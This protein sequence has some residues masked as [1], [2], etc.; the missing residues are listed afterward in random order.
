MRVTEKKRIKIDRE[1]KENPVFI[2]WVN[3]LGGREHWLFHKKQSK[4]FITQDGETYEVNQNDLENSR[5]QTY[6]F[7]KEGQDQMI[8]G[9]MADIED[10]EGIKTMLNSV[11]VEILT[12]PDT[13]TIEGPKWKNVRPVPGSFKL[14]DTDELRNELEIT[15]RFPDI[16]GQ[17]Q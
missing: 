17:M 9:T 10:I 1:C 8:V 12:N 2:S 15:L 14:Y 7:T 11:N 6:D 13:W 3:T 4:G 16:N 5:G